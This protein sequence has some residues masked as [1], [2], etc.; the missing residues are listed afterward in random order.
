VSATYTYGALSAS[1]TYYMQRTTIFGDTYNGNYATGGKGLI[2]IIGMPR[3]F[4][5]SVSFTNNGDSI[6]E[7]VS[8]YGGSN[9]N[10]QINAV[11]GNEMTI[12]QA[13]TG[14]LSSTQ[15]C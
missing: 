7:V 12:T 13:Y 15:F 9:G 8:T 2:D 1:V 5:D 10:N 14:S 4:I 11:S 6:K 3:I